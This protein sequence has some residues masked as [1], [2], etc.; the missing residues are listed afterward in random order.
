MNFAG[1]LSPD[2]GRRKNKAAR[3]RKKLAKE[4]ATE[5]VRLITKRGLLSA[6]ESQNG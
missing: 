1:N 2:K 6:G 4:I 3:K 5:V